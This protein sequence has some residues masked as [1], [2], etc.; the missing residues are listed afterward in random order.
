MK[1]PAFNCVASAFICVSNALA[2]PAAEPV[3]LQNA[4]FELDAP[5]G[6]KC[7]PKWGC[8]MHSNAESFRFF[9]DE[10]APASGRRSACIER[11]HAEPWA[12]LGQ[13]MFDNRFRGKRLRLSMV[14]RTEGV[15]VGAGP[16]IVAKGG[17][18]ESLAHAQ[19]LVKGTHAWQPMEVELDVPAQA[20][21]LTVGATLEGHGRACIDD[22]RLE[23]L[24]PGK[25]PI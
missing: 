17:A 1:T 23:V 24:P 20:S 3:I 14:V 7:L 8:T 18:G 5:A 2:A 19:R 13:A 6:D 16:W 4:G 10:T 25:S 21:V 12:V 9:L 15:E 11:I 22:V